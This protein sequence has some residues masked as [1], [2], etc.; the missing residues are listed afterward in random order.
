MHIY[1]PA[2]FKTKHQSFADSADETF[3]YVSNFCCNKQDRHSFPK[4]RLSQVEVELLLF[5]LGLAAA[6]IVFYL[7]CLRFDK[8][9]EGTGSVWIWGDVIA[10]AFCVFFSWVPAVSPVTGACLR[11]VHVRY[12]VQY[13]FSI[14]HALIFFFDGLSMG[15]SLWCAL[16]VSLPI[17][18]LALFLL[19]CFLCIG[20]FL[21]SVPLATSS[22][23]KLCHSKEQKRQNS[24]I[25]NRLEIWWVRS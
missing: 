21:L 6:K 22:Q 5:Q 25:L 7:V 9:M 18:Q 3:W 8:A 14:S 17:L 16:K 23:L 10:Q 1:E 11:L 20:M 12:K 2:W 19:T 4:P 15:W 24:Y 13:F